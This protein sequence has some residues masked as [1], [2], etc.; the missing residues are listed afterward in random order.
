MR[1]RTVR[2]E[3]LDLFVEAGSPEHREE[4]VRYLQSM[5]AADSMR[6]EWCF[7]A[8]EEEEDRTLG[9]VAF[10]TLPGMEEPFALVLLDVPWDGDYMGVGTR[11]LEDVL[12]EARGL[13]AKEIEHVLDAPPMRPQFQHRPEERVELLRSVGFA[14][15][16]ETDRFE[17]RGVEPNVEAGRLSFRTLEEV[18]DD[19]FIDAMRRVS[20]GTLDREIRQERERLGP[21]EAAREFFEDAR[22]VKHEPSWWRLAYNRPRGELVGLVMPAQPPTFLTIFYVGVVAEMRGR[23][24]VDDLLAAGTATLLEARA[25]DAKD[26]LLRAD[27]DVANAPMADAFERAGWRRFAGRREYSVDLTSERRY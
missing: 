12:N 14:F 24:Y 10:W 22:R 2:A 21:Q 4:V 15:R 5:F 20:E 16:R 6:P 9:R 26:M 13:G 7:V 11:L 19:A 23:G 25:G 1:I 18:G 27:T 8:Q 3:E 17:W